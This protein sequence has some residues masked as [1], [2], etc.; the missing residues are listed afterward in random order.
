LEGGKGGEKGNLLFFDVTPR[1]GREGG[2]KKEERGD[3]YP[4]T[5][6]GRLAMLF[7][8]L[9]HIRGEGKKKKKKRGGKEKKT[10]SN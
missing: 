3:A 7:L 1:L 6:K 10:L 2:E 5:L 8:I 9:Y 4:V